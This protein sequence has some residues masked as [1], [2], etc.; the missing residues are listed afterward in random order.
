[1]TAPIRVQRSRAK[2]WRMPDN[3]VYVG[4]PTQWG[5][6]F[7]VARNGHAGAHARYDR[8]IHTEAEMQTA[9]RRRAQIE[10]AGKN[11][12]C[13]CAPGLPCHADVLLEIANRGTK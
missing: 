8:W 13:W 6:P 9:L 1:M 11:L 5:N 3:T 12:A 4:R 10:L 2:G 7:A